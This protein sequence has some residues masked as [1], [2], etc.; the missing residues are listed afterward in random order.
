[1]KFI[2][3]I[4]LCIVLSGCGNNPQKPEVRTVYV[5]VVEPC[6]DRVPVKP[7]YKFG[8]GEKPSDD[9]ELALILAKDF[10]A[11]EQYGKDWE[12][13]SAGCILPQ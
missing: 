8:S 6:I 11:S 12:A 4:V 2:V 3:A 1:M 9:K 5:K 7:E 13:A 10:E